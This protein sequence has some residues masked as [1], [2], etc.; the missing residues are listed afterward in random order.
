MPTEPIK[1]S[2]DG[3]RLARQRTKDTVPELRL[4][5]EL[6]RRGLRFF[7][8]RRLTKGAR[9]EAD[10]VFPRAGVAVFIDGC[11]WHGCPEHA[12]WPVNNADFWRDKIEGNRIRDAET[13]S[14]LKAEGWIT[15]RV[16]EHESVQDAADR[17]EMAVRARP[18]R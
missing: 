13:D 1:Q 6:H 18:P 14:L 12:S 9:R 8:H 10:V 2:R 15:V 5:S 3:A 16:W 7:V 11:F 4:R 17:V